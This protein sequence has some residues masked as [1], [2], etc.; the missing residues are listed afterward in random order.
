M[1]LTLL[2]VLAQGAWLMTKLPQE[3]PPGNSTE[4]DSS[5]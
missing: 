2:F 4:G 1:G 3:S 5:K